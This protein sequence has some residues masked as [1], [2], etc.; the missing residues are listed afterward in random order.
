MAA[1]AHE[2][3]AHY[4]LTGEVTSIAFDRAIEL[5]PALG[6]ALAQRARLTADPVAT[7]AMSVQSCGR[8]SMALRGSRSA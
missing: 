6:E 3:H 7:I 2:L 5:N 4:L 8:A 1:V